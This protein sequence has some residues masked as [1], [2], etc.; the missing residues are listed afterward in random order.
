MKGEKLNEAFNYVEECYLEIA[1][2]EKGSRKIIWVR[3]AAMAACFCLVVGLLLPAFGQRKNANLMENAAAEMAAPSMGAHG[4]VLA[5]AYYPEMAPYPNEMDFVDA[6]T[7]EFNDEAFSE[8]HDPW[9]QDR[10]EMHRQPEGYAEGLDGFFNN[11]MAVFLSDAD[12]ENRLYSPLNVYLSLA[13]LAEVTGGDSRAQILDA[14]GA[15]SMESLQTQAESVWKAHYYND[16]STTSILADSLWL[17]DGMEYN[18]ETLNRLAEHYFASSFS[19]EMGS[20]DYNRMLQ[21]W[22]NEQTGGLLEEYVSGEQMDEKTVLA[23]ASTVYFRCKWEPEFQPGCTETGIFR[24]ADGTEV[25]TEFMNQ[26]SQGYY[27]WSEQFGA[28]RKNLQDGFSMWLLLPDEGI[29]PEA[30]LSDGKVM[31]LIANRWDS[32]KETWSW[33]DNKYLIINLSMPKFDVSSRMSLLDGLKKLGI[34]DVADRELADFSPLTEESDEIWLSNASHAVRVAV[35]EEG[36]TAAAYTVMMAEG[37]AEP[38]KDEI[39]F[40]LDRPFLFVITGAENLPVFAGIVNC[41]E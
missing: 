35:D 18:M 14:L 15:D 41:I 1:E 8:A 17:S 10:W 11:S 28:V 39:D 37:E 16:G 26:S 13:M 2:Q 7:G 40:V 6:E 20:E 36:V 21:S 33:T 30:L 27:Y 32:E 4:R 34:R 23:L 5:A 12:G 31:E 38:P 3:W 29:A 19:G 25:T 22:L 24:K 9:C